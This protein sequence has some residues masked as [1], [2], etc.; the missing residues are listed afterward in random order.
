M[1]GTARR[2]GCVAK[3]LREFRVQAIPSNMKAV[4]R[5]EDW[6]SVA[7][8]SRSSPGAAPS[9]RCA[10]QAVGYGARVLIS[11]SGE[12]WFDHWATAV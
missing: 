12:L 5:S 8:V 10:D 7:V 6:F 9:K 3:G 4:L 11:A 1:S 2:P